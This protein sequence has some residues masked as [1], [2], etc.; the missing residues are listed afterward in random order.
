MYLLH[1]ICVYIFCIYMVYIHDYSYHVF[2]CLNRAYALRDKTVS[3]TVQKVNGWQ[4]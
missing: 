4:K 2:V 3:H 1:S